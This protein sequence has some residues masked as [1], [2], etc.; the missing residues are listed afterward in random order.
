[1]ALPKKSFSDIQDNLTNRLPQ[2]S[3]DQ[4]IVSSPPKPVFPKISPPA[5]GVGQAKE[6]EPQNAD[7]EAKAQAEEDKLVAEI[8]TR[9]ESLDAQ[10]LGEMQKVINEVKQGAAESIKLPPDVEDAGVVAP[11]QKAEEVVKDGATVVLPIEEETYK[12]GLKVKVSAK[13]MV[14]KVAV[15]ASSLFALAAW[16]GRLIKMAH[17][18]TMRVM[19]KGGSSD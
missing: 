16:V 5:A 6:H 11:E 8:K 13:T 15:G 10:A 3:G 18:H 19:F 12:K 1:M 14:D 4:T 9:G 17:R 2:V 7:S